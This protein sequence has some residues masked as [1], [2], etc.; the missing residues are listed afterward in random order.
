MKYLHIHALFFPVLWLGLYLDSSLIS[1]QWITNILVFLT[2][3]WLY[4]Q[5]SKQIKQLMLYGLIVALGGE[6]LFSL[7]FGM[8]T[9][10][11]ENLPIYVP[12]G[13]AIIYACVYYFVK[14]PIVLKH[15]DKIIKFLY[16]AILLYSTAW[17]IFAND[18]FGFLCLLVILWIFKRRPKTKL[19]FLFMFFAIVYL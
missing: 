9:Y 10:R 8:Y 2:F 17:L 12:F 1:Q 5:V 14:E 11:L 13:H 15:Q 4:T 19:F 16:V 18:I 6:L 3:I 7:V